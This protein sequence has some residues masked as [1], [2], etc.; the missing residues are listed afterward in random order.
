LIPQKSANFVEQAT[1][2]LWEGD[3]FAFVLP[4]SFLTGSNKFGVS[5]IREN[6]SKKCELFEVWQCPEGT[7]G[8]DAR[9]DVC[10]LVGAVGKSSMQHTISRA[11]ISRAEACAIRENGFLGSS[12][13][14]SA[15]ASAN[16]DTELSSLVSPVNPLVQT[17]PLAS[18]FFVFNGVKHHAGNT[19]VK[20]CPE[21]K[22][23]KPTWRMRWRKEGSFWAD[24]EVVNQGMRWVIYDSEALE[25]PRFKVSHLFDRSKILVGRIANRAS[26]R[27]LTVQLDTIGFCPNDSVWCILPIATTQ[28]EL[29]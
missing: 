11:V 20:H 29:R 4:S 9:Q 1:S 3:Q 10:I 2:W 14:S 26:N 8:V 27:P 16:A 7:V 12:W 18:L 21:Y 17:V 25:R 15:S 5:T 6:L 22:L 23:C 28:K 19:P 13:I 24:P